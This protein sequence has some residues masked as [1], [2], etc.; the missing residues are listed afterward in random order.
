MNS[1]SANL[2]KGLGFEK[3]GNQYRDSDGL[4]WQNVKLSLVRQYQV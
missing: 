4:E 3:S 2:L 1:G